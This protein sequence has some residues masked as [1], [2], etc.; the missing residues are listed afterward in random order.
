[1]RVTSR[2]INLF[3]RGGALDK[4]TTRELD[5]RRMRNVKRE[6]MCDYKHTCTCARLMDN[7]R[8]V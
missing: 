7:S 6:G 1:V 5:A 8:G 4:K 2:I 3:R